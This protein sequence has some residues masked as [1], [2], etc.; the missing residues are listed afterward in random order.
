MFF[1]FRSHAEVSSVNAETIRRSNSAK[2]ICYSLL[3]INIAWKVSE[4]LIQ[5]MVKAMVRHR[6]LTVPWARVYMTKGSNRSLC[7][8]SLAAGLL[9]CGGSAIIIIRFRLVIF[10]PGLGEYF[11]VSFL[12]REIWRKKSRLGHLK[13]LLKNCRLLLQSRKFA[14]VFSVFQLHLSTWGNSS[15]P[16]NEFQVLCQHIFF[17]RSKQRISESLLLLSFIITAI[18]NFVN[19]SKVKW[20]SKPEPFVVRSD[21]WS[22]LMK[23]ALS[24]TVKFKIEYPLL[25]CSKKAP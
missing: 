12:C 11:A 8:F 22:E 17:R 19:D 14:V 9:V 1:G 16:K 6:L 24:Y 23:L 21:K 7:T 13:M 10:M 5:S 20:K 18:V 3:N 25:K 4:K 15:H 2:R